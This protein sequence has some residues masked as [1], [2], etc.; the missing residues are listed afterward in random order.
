MHSQIMESLVSEKDVSLSNIS[1]TD[2]DTLI[3]R[4]DLLEFASRCVIAYSPWFEV[5]WNRFDNPHL[6]A[7][8][9]TEMVGILSYYKN[10]ELNSI[11]LHF[12][13]IEEKYRRLG[14]YRM[15]FNTLVDKAREQGF[16]RID[17]C[18]ETTNDVSNTTHRKSGSQYCIG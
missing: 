11:F 10:N 2:F 6:V 12:C 5:D 14:I 4:E 18:V 15:M 9:D 16:R 8:L 7:Y 13:F 17:F 3:G 1:I